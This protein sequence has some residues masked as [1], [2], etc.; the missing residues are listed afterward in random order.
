MVKTKL[1]KDRKENIQHVE[2]SVASHCKQ[3]E[4]PI[5]STSQINYLCAGLK[6][7]IEVWRLSGMVT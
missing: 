7:A 3:F 4:R 5:A 6:S 1:S 2:T